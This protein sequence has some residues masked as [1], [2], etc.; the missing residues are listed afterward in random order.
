MKNYVMYDDKYLGPG[1]L[2]VS[3][4]N[5]KIIKFL[6]IYTMDGYGFR[7]FGLRAFSIF[8]KDNPAKEYT[9]IDFNFNP[10]DD[11]ENNLYKIFHILCQ[12]LNGK[13]VKT[14]D[15]F[16]QGKNHFSLKEDDNSVTLLVAKDVYGV[17]NATDFIDINIGDDISCEDYRAIAT[18]Y[19]Q[20]ANSKSK[21]ADRGDIEELLLTRIR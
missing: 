18:L 4:E 17:R 19:M 11:K 7:S 21:E 12:S 20:L 5:D 13:K 1:Y 15:K 6:K 9:I 2:I 3:K 10:N 8:G 16:Y 14:I